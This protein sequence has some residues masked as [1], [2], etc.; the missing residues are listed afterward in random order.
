[1][2]K[3]LENHNLYA[4][5]TILFWSLAFLFTKQAVASFSPFAAGLLRY[6]VASGTLLIIVVAL[7][8]KPPKKKDI[9]TF[10]VSGFVGFFLYMIF[11]NTATSMLSGGTCSLVI[12]LTPVLTSIEA[13]I[14]FGEKLKPYQWL[15]TA[16]SFAGV[17]ALVIMNKENSVG[18]GVY[19]A[20]GAAFV[21]ASYNIWQRRLTKTYSSLQASAYS[22]F[23][24]T[25]FL[26]V[27]GGKAAAELPNASK[28]SIIA[29][30]FLGIFSSAVAY[31]SWSKAFALAKK[32]SDVSNFMFLTPF[33]TTVIGIAF[34]G[35]RL[36]LS[37]V[38]G[39]VLI[40][41]GILL[42]QRENFFKK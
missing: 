3:L 34:A 5:I 4:G 7:K 2:K 6:L 13:A 41:S 14:L 16:I 40:L 26:C 8:I 9:P 10:V 11:F 1:M 25:L 17:A 30:L 21:L 33:L 27:F 32:T 22:I 20:A 12:A 38:I 29:I 15:A 37:T 28:E 24:G 35:E 42:F 36:E 19:W 31:V 18:V 23:F 39:G